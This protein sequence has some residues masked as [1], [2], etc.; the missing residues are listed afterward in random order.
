MSRPLFEVGEE[1]ILVSQTYPA[2]NGD[3]HVIR[4]WRAEENGPCKCTYFY[5]LTCGMPELHAAM[6]NLI[7][8]LRG[9]RPLGWHQ[10]AL[11]KKPKPGQDFDELLKELDKPLVRRRSPEETEVKILS[12]GEEE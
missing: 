5:D 6:N 12:N 7:Q 9:D 3:T 10:C 1:V 2:F 11:R 4:V 8:K